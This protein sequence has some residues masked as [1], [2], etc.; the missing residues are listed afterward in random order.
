[1][2]ASS[3]NYDPVSTVVNVDTNASPNCKGVVA[4]RP[5]YFTNFTNVS[6]GS[7]V[8]GFTKTGTD[9]YFADVPTG[10]GYSSYITI[11]NQNATVASVTATFYA[12]GQVSQTL[13]KAVQPNTRDTIIPTNSGTT[14]EHAAVHVHSDQQVMVERPS[15][16]DDINGGNAGVVSGAASVIGVQRDNVDWLFAEG[17]TGSGFQEDLVLSNFETSV[18]NAN[19][20]LEYSNGSTQTVQYQV[21][22]NDQTLVDVN[23]LRNNTSVGTCTPSPC[24]PTLDVSAEVTS[25]NPIVA[26]REMYFHYSDHGTA[27]IGVSDVTG[28]VAPAAPAYTFAEGYTNA[29]YNEW[30]TL[31]N[32]TINPETIDVTLINGDGRSYAF[33]VPTAA[34]SRTTINITSIVGTSLI[35]PN[36]TYLGYE[37][38]MIVQSTAGGL[39][40]AERPMYWNTYSNTNPNGTQ[41]GSAVFGYTGG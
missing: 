38:S 8:V 19:V 14:V 18:A 16:F 35:Q 31:Q 26:Q 10:G 11:L 17:Y 23:G 13:T 27:A 7:D 41:G 34:H 1:M 21:Q 37:V 6:S 12:G 36:D 33:E 22:P 25:D 30:L 2:P 40:V 32:P 3:T 9:F 20:I 39:F 24:Q 29:G 4:E 28:L 5:V 15:Y